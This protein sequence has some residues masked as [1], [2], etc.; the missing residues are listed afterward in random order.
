MKDDRSATPSMDLVMAMVQIAASAPFSTAHSGR[1][2][3]KAR[4]NFSV[5]DAPASADA[6]ALSA[7]QPAG[8]TGPVSSR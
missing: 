5:Q 6:T 4:S 2:V 3:P 8:H 7:D 1:P